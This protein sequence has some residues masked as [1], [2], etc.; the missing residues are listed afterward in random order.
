MSKM[1]AKYLDLTR[2][3]GKILLMRAYVQNVSLPAT[4]YTTSLI[5]LVD[6]AG[7]A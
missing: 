7:L 3:K 2:Q 4:N 1:K 5:L 6:D